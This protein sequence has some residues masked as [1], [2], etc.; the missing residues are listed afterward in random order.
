MQIDKG[1]Y[2]CWYMTSRCY[3]QTVPFHI[4]Q[5]LNSIEASYF[6][7]DQKLISAMSNGLKEDREA[8]IALKRG[9]LKTMQAMQPKKAQKHRQ[10]IHICIGEI[11]TS[12]SV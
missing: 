9:R 8:K 10:K 4:H 6:L 3:S 1:T 7:Y 5:E 12:I 11:I 2:S